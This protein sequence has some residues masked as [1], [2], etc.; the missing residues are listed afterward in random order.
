[1]LADKLVNNLAYDTDKEVQ[2]LELLKLRF[3]E[4]SMHH[5]EIMVR[6][7]LRLARWL[8]PSLPVK[9]SRPS[10]VLSSPTLSSLCAQG[11]RSSKARQDP[12]AADEPFDLAD[13]RPCIVWCCSVSDLLRGRLVPLKVRDVEESKRVN[14]NVQERIAQRRGGDAHKEDADAR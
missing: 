2:N 6:A 1:M 13:G 10:H 12:A 3:G 4:A 11:Q 9:C 5:C 7:L 8:L 14:A